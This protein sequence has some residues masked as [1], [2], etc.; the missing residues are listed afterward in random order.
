M[1]TLPPLPKR[2]FQEIEPSKVIYSSPQS[3]GEPAGTEAMNSSPPP[4]AMPRC[5]QI[6]LKEPGRH[7]GTPSKLL[8]QRTRKRMNMLTFKKFIYRTPKEM[9]GF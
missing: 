3:G 9:K 5:K 6:E 7:H 1:A 2:N 4:L 8:R